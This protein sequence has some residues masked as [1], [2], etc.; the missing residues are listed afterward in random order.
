MGYWERL[1]RLP[2]CN[3]RARAKSWTGAVM[4]LPHPRLVQIWL[5]A[6]CR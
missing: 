3:R 4:H 1:A 2:G 6:L 5:L